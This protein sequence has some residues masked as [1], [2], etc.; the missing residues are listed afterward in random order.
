MT[1]AENEIQF[2]ENFY[3][4]VYQPEL[5]FEDANIIERIKDHPMA[6]WRMMGKFP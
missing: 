2:V 4:G 5:L 1:L 6:V 3:L